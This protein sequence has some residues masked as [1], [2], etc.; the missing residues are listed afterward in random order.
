MYYMSESLT[1]CEDR[2]KRVSLNALFYQVT[3]YQVINVTN[4]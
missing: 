1:S 3:S 4:F 2:F